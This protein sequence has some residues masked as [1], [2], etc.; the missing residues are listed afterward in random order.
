M[1][2]KHLYLHTEEGKLGKGMERWHILI[3][4][5]KKKSNLWRPNIQF[6]KTEKEAHIGN[7]MIQYLKFTT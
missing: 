7:I 6:L 1:I 4:I 5:L 3:Y 2:Y